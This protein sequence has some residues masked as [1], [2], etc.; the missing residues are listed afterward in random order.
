MFR[1]SGK[2]GEPHSSIITRRLSRAYSCAQCRS[3]R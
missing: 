3:A 2:A 1:H